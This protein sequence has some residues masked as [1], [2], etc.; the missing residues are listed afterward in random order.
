MLVGR[1]SELDTLDAV[2]ASA[3]GG[4][5]SAV[6]V[7]GEAGI[8]KSR[9]AAEAVGHALADNTV[10]MRGRASAMGPSVPFRPITE[11]LLSLLRRGISPSAEALGPYRAVLGSLVPEWSAE[12][13]G[14]HVGSLVLLAEAILRLTAV[15]GG[16]E[17]CLLVLEDLHDADVETL[18]VVEYLCDNLDSQATTL[19]STVR[20]EPGAALDLA[21]SAGRRPSGTTIE[22]GRLG[23]TEVRALVASCLDV[24]PGEVPSAVADRLWADGAGVPFVVEELLYGMVSSGKLVQGGGGWQLIAEGRAGLP[25]TLMRSITQRIER[26]GPHGSKLLSVAAV[27]GHRFSLTVLQTVVGVDDHDLLAHL[28]A[29]VEAQLIAP[30]ERG[31]DWYTFQHPLTA[32]AL[33]T[34]LT[35]V[36]RAEV[37]RR[38]AEAAEKFHPD[39]EGDWCQLTAMLRL[40]AGDAVT[41]AKLFTEAGR[42]AL[43]AGAA[44]SAIA[45][46]ERAEGL[47]A[48]DGDAASRADVLETLL[49]ALAE[50]G[51]FDRAF[52][53]AGSLDDDGAGVDAGRRIALHVRL[54]WAAH[55][56]GRWNDGVAHVAAARALLDPDA[57][58]DAVAPIDAVAAYLALEGPGRGRLHEAETLARR[59]VASASAIAAVNVC[60]AW[61]IIGLVARER[62]LEEARVCF[63]RA[64]QIAEDHQ[65]PIWRLYATIGLAGRTWLADSRVDVLES[66]RDTALGMGA[67][68]LAHNMEATIAMHWVLAGDIPT[69]DALIVECL[70]HVERLR[71]TSVARYLHMCRATVAAHQGRRDEMDAALA[72]FRANDGD[73]S[74][75]RPLAFGLARAVCA[76]LEENVPLAEREL[77]VVALVEAENPTT[78]Y[79][80][81]THGM[82]VLLQVLN[83]SMDDTQFRRISATAPAAMRWNQ[84][85]VLLAE[86]VLLGRRGRTTEATAVA[87]RAAALAEPFVM[88]RHLGPRLI[89]ESAHADGWGT[90]VVWLRAA[91]EHFHQASVPVVASACRTLLRKFGASV[92]QRRTGTARVPAELRAAGVTIREFEVFE[93]LPNRL[94]NKAVAARLHISPRTVEKHVASLLHKTGRP[95]RA[96]LADYASTLVTT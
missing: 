85:F 66:A 53:L 55:L 59:L 49:Y 30:D 26:L 74:Q 27:L 42:R 46:L 5:G 36:D 11:A 37:S 81:G 19:L 79:L 3:R 93:L 29:G 21:R 87:E 94:G 76:L 57:A 20:A 4:Q 88:A 39:L 72:D 18:A 9:L 95:D 10:V 17:G 67:I 1:D 51:E 6:F 68:T 54:A 83:G 80:A 52:T 28:R 40:G 65:L 82:R 16:D 24:G 35:P 48:G 43:A 12:G 60:Q 69:A 7:L 64:R 32:E 90:P 44:G 38:A 61:H 2:L 45:L 22:L 47:L 50:S 71:L 89:A 62:D 77:D 63:E 78:F 70:S 75:E 73:R 86:A 33:L 41:A 91:E 31:P 25:G 8:G 56:A 15:V 92:Q 96:S 13:G 34:L 23:Q 14:Q 84:Q 58:D